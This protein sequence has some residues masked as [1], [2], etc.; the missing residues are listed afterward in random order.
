MELKS[1]LNVDFE[2]RTLTYKSPESVFLGFAF[3]APKMTD[4]GFEILVHNMD[5][6]FDCIYNNEEIRKKLPPL[7]KDNVISICFEVFKD[8]PYKIRDF[9]VFTKQVSEWYLGSLDEYTDSFMKISD[10]IDKQIKS[11]SK[12]EYAAERLVKNKLIKIITEA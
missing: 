12:A 3:S 11:V 5:G 4:E 6:I 7:R 9:Y 2:K 8:Y 10:D 1:L